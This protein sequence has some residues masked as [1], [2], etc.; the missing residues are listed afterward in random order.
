METISRTET[1]YI[2]RLVRKT[3]GELPAGDLL[4]LTLQAFLGDSSHSELPFTL[5]TGSACVGIE[6]R[7]GSVVIDSIC[8]LDFRLIEA[9]QGKLRLDAPLPHP[10]VDHAIIR[11]EIPF[12]A[13]DVELMLVDAAGYSR[14]LAD[15]YHGAGGYEAALNVDATA[16]G[17]YIVRLRVGEM[18]KEISILVA[19]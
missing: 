6:S 14:R 3:P 13:S 19:R 17:M 8:G 10:V 15:G 4:E 11:Y 9:A 5:T 16:P 7:P 12:D 1:G 2:A 18:V